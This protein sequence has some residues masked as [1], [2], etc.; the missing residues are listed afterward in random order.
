MAV[1]APAAAATR[2]SPALSWLLGLLNVLFVLG[3]SASPASPPPPVLSQWTGVDF[4]AATF[5][6]P[7]S[8]RID[9]ITQRRQ[10]RFPVYQ[11]LSHHANAVPGVSGSSTA[12]LSSRANSS[13]S[14]STSTNAGSTSTNASTA[15]RLCA[16]T[17]EFAALD[18]N[19]GIGTFFSELVA[20]AH[21]SWG[22]DVT[23]LYTSV[24]DTSKLTAFRAAHPAVQVHVV[25]CSDVVVVGYR[26]IFARHRTQQKGYC[27]ARWLYQH[28]QQQ[29]R[30]Q[31]LQQQQKK[32]KSKK[33]QQQHHQ[34][35][36]PW[37]FDVVH[38]HENAGV[39][40]VAAQLRALELAFPHTQFVTTMHGDSHWAQL[41]SYRF[42]ASV[43]VHA[44]CCARSVRWFRAWVGEWAAGGW[45]SFR[46]S[47]AA[48]SVYG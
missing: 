47:L 11:A 43:R 10:K 46:P 14:T 17:T 34:E 25:D 48:G 18:N 4:E 3:T 19:G 5:L 29:R 31:Q 23:V 33:Q 12:D 40:A 26:K 7:F 2:A 42:Y 32:K 15:I 36:R 22:W 24:P 45:P 37:A 21:G 8:P 6:E 1:H 38:L 16:V 30:R 27:V 44:R 41:L 20:A 28:H 13:T 35:Q 39:G 9:S